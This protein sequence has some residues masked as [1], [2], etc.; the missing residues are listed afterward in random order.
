MCLKTVIKLLLSKYGILSIEMQRA[1]K[2][3][4]A[5]V[6]GDFTQM[7]SI[8]DIDDAEVEYADNPQQNADIDEE[9]AKEVQKKFENFD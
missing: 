2:F 3:D 8:D 1:I 5:I 4:S 7:D 6:K 9:K